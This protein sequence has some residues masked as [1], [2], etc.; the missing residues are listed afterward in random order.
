ML[1]ILSN[2]KMSSNQILVWTSKILTICLQVCIL[3][4]NHQWKTRTLRRSIKMYTQTIIKHNSSIQ[5]LVKIQINLIWLN[6]KARLS[7]QIYS[8]RKIHKSSK[9]MNPTFRN[10]WGLV[11]S[12][13]A[14][15][16][17]GV[18]MITLSIKQLVHGQMIW[19]LRMK[20]WLALQIKSLKD[21]KRITKRKL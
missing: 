11:L 10:R 17:L 20:R 14:T 13:W 1:E 9:I 12:P 7:V 2:H 4:F 16:R 3:S 21:W 8:S 18:S 19:A 5:K 15:Y 6:S